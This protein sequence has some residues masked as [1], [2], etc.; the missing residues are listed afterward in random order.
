MRDAGTR[1]THTCLCVPYLTHV[2]DIQTTTLPLRGGVVF[3]DLIKQCF[4][5]VFVTFL[6]DTTD[7]L[8]KFMHWHFWHFGT[9]SSDS[10][11]SAIS[12]MRFFV[13]LF[14]PDCIRTTQKVI[15]SLYIR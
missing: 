10:A 1:R 7:I 6:V 5:W 13:C 11:N 15:Y 14:R 9:F 3:F 2:Y 12:A 4:L 8:I